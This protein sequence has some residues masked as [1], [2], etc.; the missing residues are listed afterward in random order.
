[1]AYLSR[2]RLPTLGDKQPSFFFTAY[3]DRLWR[4]YVPMDLLTNLTM[5]D[6]LS[7]PF[8]RLGNWTGWHIRNTFYNSQHASL[9]AQI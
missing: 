9:T 5:N 6:N 2:E 3:M 8:C 7:V 4:S 1:M